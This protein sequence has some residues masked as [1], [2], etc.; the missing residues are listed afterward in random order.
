MKKKYKKQITLGTDYSGKRVRKWI[1]ADSPTALKKKEREEILKFSKRKA[2]NIVTVEKYLE[3]WFDAYASKLAINTREAYRTALR[4]LKPIYHKRMDE[5]TRTDLQKIVNANWEHPWMCK[6]LIGKMGTI[7]EIAAAEGVVDRNIAKRLSA[8]KAISKERRPLS[9][10]EKEGIRNAD[11]T[12]MER[13]FVDIEYQFG[14]RPGEA[15]CLCKSDI[16]YKEKTMTIS[17]SLTHEHNM[18]VIKKTKTEKIR[19]LPVPDSFLERFKKIKTFYF[20][21]SEDEKLFTKKEVDDFKA[22]VLQKI[23]V[24]MG[25]NENLKVTDM[26]CY[27]LRHNRATDLYYENSTDL[28]TKAKASYMGHSEAMFIQRYSHI[29]PEKENQEVLR[30]EVM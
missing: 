30:K 15:F 6:K 1:Y 16:S 28:S 26:V 17:K 5:V 22:S 8:P 24:A 12:P 11:F 21:M 2:D 4:K 3:D 7:W 14:L 27:N 19:V 20:F 18:P 25:G 9:E 10:A 23:N 29:R 13:L